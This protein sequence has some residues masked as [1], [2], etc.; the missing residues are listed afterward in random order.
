MARYFHYTSRAHAQQIWIGGELRPGASGVLYLTPDLYDKGYQAAESLAIRGKPVE[1]ALAFED[2][3][4]QK[5]C[6]NGE[7]LSP[8]RV[9]PIREGGRLVR[10]GGGAECF[11]KST[12]PLTTEV[13]LLS[14]REP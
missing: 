14:L 9:E 13:M 11:M 10:V 4:V 1:V 8:T 12:L 5:S 3:H 2:D 6:R 7:D